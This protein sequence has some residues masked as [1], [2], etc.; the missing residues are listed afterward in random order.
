MPLAIAEGG[1]SSFA[2]E[3]KH[4][5]HSREKR[6]YVENERRGTTKQQERKK[7]E[8]EEKKRQKKVHCR[9]GYTEKKKRK[10]VD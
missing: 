9:E 5:T 4:K 6:V 1:F 2:T 3:P 8:E 10:M 7:E